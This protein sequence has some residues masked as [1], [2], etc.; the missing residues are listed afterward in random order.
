M[1]ETILIITA[2]AAATGYLSWYALRR[3]R[4]GGGCPG[5]GRCGADPATYS[6]DQHHGQDHAATLTLDGRAVR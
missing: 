5:C 3:L 6:A 4:G 1:L 2:V